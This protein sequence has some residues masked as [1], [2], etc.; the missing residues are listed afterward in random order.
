ME[1]KLNIGAEVEELVMTLVHE[2]MTQEDLLAQSPKETF[3]ALDD[4]QDW[5]EIKPVGR[6]M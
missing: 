3:K 1:D 5:I 4:D 6:E 2:P